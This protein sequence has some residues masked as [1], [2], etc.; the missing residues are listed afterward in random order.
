MSVRPGRAALVTFLVVAPAHFVAVF[1]AWALA[2]APSRADHS[3]WLNLF[4][5]L[6]LP[7]SLLPAGVID[8]WFMP[9]LCANSVV[10]AG[11]IAWLVR[12]LAQGRT[13]R[14]PPAK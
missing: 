1:F 11:G 7:A 9:V 14:S 3:F 10:W 2:D 13:R 4:N 12:R 6:F 5:V 8:W